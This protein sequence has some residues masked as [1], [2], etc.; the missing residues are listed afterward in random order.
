MDQI[1]FWS[2]GEI[3]GEMNQSRI[4]DTQ[5]VMQLWTNYSTTYKSV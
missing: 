4:K 5:N 3:S 2:Q 1:F